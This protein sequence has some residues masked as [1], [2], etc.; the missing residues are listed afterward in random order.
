MRS[1]W[2]P[3]DLHGE[4]VAEGR[5]RGKGASDAKAEALLYRVLLASTKPG[6]LVLDPILRHRHDGRGGKAAVQ[7]FIGIE[8]DPT[9]A[10]AAT[11]RIAATRPVPARR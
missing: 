5:D 7:H 10:D 3:A 9:Y 11:Q 8:R 1:H 4:R 6:D 2:S